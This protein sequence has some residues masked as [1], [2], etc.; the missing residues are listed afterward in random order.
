MSSLLVPADFRLL[1]PVVIQLG[2]MCSTAMF[3]TLTAVP[4]EIVDPVVQ[5]VELGAQAFELPG[6]DGIANSHSPLEADPNSGGGC[7]TDDNHDHFH[8]CGL[9]EP[10]DE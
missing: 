6:I 5:F 8:E 9:A 10:A 2:R 7:I 4:V 1:A 3:A